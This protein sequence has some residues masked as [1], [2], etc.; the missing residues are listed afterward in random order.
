M[1]INWSGLPAGWTIELD[2]DGTLELRRHDG[3]TGVDDGPVEGESHEECMIRLIR[4]A[5]ELERRSNEAMAG[6]AAQADC[7]ALRGDWRA[8]GNDIRR[9]L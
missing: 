2:A 9:S 5:R 4:L 1:L 6:D 7:E 8:I 3:A